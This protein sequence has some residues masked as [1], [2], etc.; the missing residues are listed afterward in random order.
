MTFRVTQTTISRNTLANLQLNLNKLQDIQNQ[1]SSG[2]RIMKPSDDP[3]SA[4]AAMQIRSDQARTQQY[5][6]NID[7]G[8]A[9][10]G[11]ADSALTQATTMLQRVRQLV[12]SGI[13][14]TNGPDERGAMADEVST[15]RDGMIGIANTQYLG[16]A[17]F[18]GTVD[19]TRLATP[20]T[21]PQA[22][23]KTTGAYLGN[24]SPVMR[25]VSAGTQVQVNITGDQAF[26]TL[27]SGYSGSTGLIDKVVTDLRS[28]DTNALTSDLSALDTAAQQMSS[29]HSLVGARYNRLQSMQSVANAHLDATTQ[30]LS[31]AED[32][33][34]PKTIID[35]QLQQTAYQAALGA[36]AKIVQPS[37]LDFLH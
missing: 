13:N 24:T 22:Y 15:L 11:S 20:T 7:D 19:S 18:S 12:T 5:G 30:A 14:A 27:F 2:K 28:G 25:T 34:L 33:D 23:D 32:I 6:R 1:L 17:L 31:N 9:R 29:A 8:L 3:V 16:Q 26:G 35:L 21:S 37:L 4:V 36:T 10:L